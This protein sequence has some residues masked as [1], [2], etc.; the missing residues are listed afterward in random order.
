YD[1]NGDL[2]ASSATREPTDSPSDV[3][4]AIASGKRTGQYDEVDGRQVYSYFVPLNGA[5][6]EMIGVLRVTSKRSS[7]VRYI[8]ALRTHGL[9]LLA[10]TTLALT[11]I[12]L[13]GYYFAVGRSL[14]SFARSIHRVGGGELAHRADVRR[15]REVAL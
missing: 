5:G 8:D 7:L 1:R 10:L 13:V 9:V 14:T 11:G 15:P 6:G 3:S 2:V 12:V 4:N